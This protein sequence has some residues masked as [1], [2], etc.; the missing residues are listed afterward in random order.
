MNNQAGCRHAG[1]QGKTEKAGHTE[2]KQSEG[3]RQQ[4]TH[5]KRK[6]WMRERGRQKEDQGG[7]KEGKKGKPDTYIRGS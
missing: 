1:R 5:R 2:R 3:H 4:K 6:G 7:R